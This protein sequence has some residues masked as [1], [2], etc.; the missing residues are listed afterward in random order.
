MRNISVIL[1]LS[2]ILFGFT[3]PKKIETKIEK[4]I[5]SVFEISSFEKKNLVLSDSINK[6]LLVPFK[7]DNF[8]KITS[9]KKLLGYFYYGKAPSKTDVFDF[10][11]IFN[12]E[13]IL[14]KIKIVAY[15]ENYG[16]EISSK[17]WLKQFELLTKEDSAVYRENIQAISGATISAK[18]M[19]RTINNLLKSLKI[20]QNKNQI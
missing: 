16:N 13:L 18:S 20:L 1:F 19:T 3:I 15:R 12:E 14:K 11:V 4:E 17:R 8:F 2:V 6:N 7:E 5:K 10:V 9:N